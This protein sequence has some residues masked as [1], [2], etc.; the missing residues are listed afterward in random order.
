MP[1]ARK[2]YDAG[3]QRLTLTEVRQMMLEQSALFAP[4]DII[5][6]PCNPDALAMAVCDLKMARGIRTAHSPTPG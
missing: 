3:R 5:P 6:V 2:N 4:A 1:G